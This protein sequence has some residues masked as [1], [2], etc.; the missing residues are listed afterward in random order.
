MEDEMRIRVLSRMEVE[1]G[2][3]QGADAVISIRPSAVAAEPEL[4]IALAQAARG[5]SARLLKLSY[6]DI[7][8]AEYG[9]F[10]GPT[11]AQI[12]DAIEFGRSISDGRHLFDGP[13]AEPPLI[14]VHCEHG[15]SRSAAIA[16]ALLADH[17]GDGRE[18]D[19]VNALMR[20]DVEGRMHPNPLV[21]SLADSCLFRY[22]RLEAALAELSPRYVKWRELWRQITLDPDAY[23]EKASRILSQRR[24]RNG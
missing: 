12:A 13:G 8:M 22:G 11:M 2:G 6:D 19:A 9:H 5:E 4:A 16:L 20:A 18:H 23:W 15:K 21:V 14:A 1:T 10:R 17:L 24:R 7:G 3:A